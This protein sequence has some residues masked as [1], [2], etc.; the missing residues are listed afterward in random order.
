MNE[1]KQVKTEPYYY[2]KLVN[3]VL[4]CVILVLSILIILNDK[5][6]ILVPAVFFLGFLM[7]SLSG[8]M[9]LARNKKV[10]GYICSVFAGIL[11]VALI[12]SIIQIW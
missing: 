11:M 10:I 2:V 12:I 5:D 9:G 1:N 7:C 4:A 6:G 8:I 3:I